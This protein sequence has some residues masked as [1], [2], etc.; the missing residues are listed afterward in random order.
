M[1]EQKN[2]TIYLRD[3]TARTKSSA[4]SAVHFAAEPIRIDSPYRRST[5][6]RSTHLARAID[7]KEGEEEKMEESQSQ[8][9]STFA[10]GVSRCA[11]RLDEF[12]HEQAAP[13]RSSGFLERPR[14]ICT[15]FASDRVAPSFLARAAV[16]T[17]VRHARARRILRWMSL[18]KN[19]P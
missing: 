6:K 4:L 8:V 17:H 16:C 9:P 2:N 19:L 15:S 7:P 12:T 1:S 10:A 5:A 13:T 14:S 11:S 18:E 3:F